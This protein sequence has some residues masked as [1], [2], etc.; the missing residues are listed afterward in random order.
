MS[1]YELSV[2]DIP[3]VSLWWQ[4]IY[5]D[6]IE[7]FPEDGSIPND[8][9]VR[10]FADTGICMADI[11]LYWRELHQLDG[12]P[13]VKEPY[14]PRVY[15]QPTKYDPTTVQH[16]F[17]LQRFTEVTGVKIEDLTN[18]YEWGAGFGSLAR[19][20]MDK[21]Y[22]AYTIIDLPLLIAVQQVYLKLCGHVEHDVR[23]LSPSEACLLDSDLLY[24]DLFVAMWSLEES[25]RYAQ[26]FVMEREFF[27]A[28][29]VLLAFQSDKDIFS[30]SQGFK[31][32]LPS[33]LTIVSAE[34]EASHYAFR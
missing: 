1:R 28:A 26:D 34:A 33:D 24:P 2:E 5:Q 10:L 22:A 7:R 13:N 16:L 29:H 27:G 9:L 4:R 23:W 25:T 18:V 12:P 31:D 32:R 11:Y 8:F 3:F 30:D 20:I 19:L 6:L 15:Y 17:T 21:S 14:L